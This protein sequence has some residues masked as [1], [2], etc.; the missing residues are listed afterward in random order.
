[1]ADHER[2]LHACVDITTPFFSSRL[3][4]RF[5][6]SQHPSKYALLAYTYREHYRFALE[7]ALHH[8][9]DEF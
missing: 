7:A 8:H 6:L 9:G 2:A 1:M 3:S 4:L 5:A